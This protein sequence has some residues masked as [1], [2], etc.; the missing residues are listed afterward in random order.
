MQ[1]E[2]KHFKVNDIELAAQCW[3]NGDQHRVLCLHG[4]L[5]NSESF[6]AVAPLLNNCN[7]V[8][9]DMAGHGLSSHRSAHGSYNIWDDH[10]D[11]LAV[12]EQLGWETFCLLGHSRGGISS[13]L[14]AT[15]MPQQVEQLILLDGM[16]PPP[17]EARS[18][19]KQLGMFLTQRQRLSNKKRRF[20]TSIEQALENRK[21]LTSVNTDEVLSMVARDLK[22][23]VKG[24]VYRHDSRLKGASAVKFTPAQEVEFL[25]ELAVKTLA[26]VAEK[27]MLDKPELLATINTHPYIESHLVGGGHHFHLRKGYSEKLAQVINLWLKK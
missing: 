9:L 17:Q 18:A 2:E 8:A 19:A 26:F 1:A 15:A 16:L 7:V 12:T 24:Y 23:T 3:H 25:Q 14:Y 10:I 21:L 6:A 13:F 27:G 20:Y 5:D 4:W 22:E 11:I